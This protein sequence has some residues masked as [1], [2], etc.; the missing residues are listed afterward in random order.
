MMKLIIVSVPNLGTRSIPKT[1]KTGMTKTLM[2]ASMPTRPVTEA[3]AAPRMPLRKTRTPTL[4]TATSF[5]VF[6]AMPSSSL[7]V[8]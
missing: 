6:Q 4:P 3:A 7:I 5:V 1:I 2:N 8:I